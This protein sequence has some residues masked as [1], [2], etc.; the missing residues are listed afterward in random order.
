MREQGR[1]GAIAA[2]QLQAEANFVAPALPA[3]AQRS[4]TP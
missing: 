2:R 4:A 1:G 3:R